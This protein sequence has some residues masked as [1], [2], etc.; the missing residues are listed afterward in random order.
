MPTDNLLKEYQKKQKKFLNDIKN[1]Q[2]QFSEL[3]AFYLL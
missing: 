2:I 1:F 3:Q